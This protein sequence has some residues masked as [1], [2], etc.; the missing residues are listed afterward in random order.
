MQ[1]AEPRT[2]GAKFLARLYVF[3]R[4][5]ARD[6]GETLACKKIRGRLREEDESGDPGGAS[7]ALELGH[8]TVPQTAP[9]EILSDDH[10]AQER[11]SSEALQRAGRHDLA[12]LMDD[13]KLR[14][15]RFEIAGR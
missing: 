8:D 11:R 10:R 4:T 3:G 12:I 15:R 14:P 2:Q 13:G 1:I 5:A 7:Q 6:R 9:P